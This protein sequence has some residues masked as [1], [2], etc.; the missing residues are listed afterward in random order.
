MVYLAVNKSLA[1]GCVRKRRRLEQFAGL[2]VLELFA[3]DHFARVLSRDE[4]KAKSCR[5]L[6]P[7]Q[8]IIG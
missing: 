5:E 7:R 3:A 4:Q 8:F 6:A 1:A 2:R